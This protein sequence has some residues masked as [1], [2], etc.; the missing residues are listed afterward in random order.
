MN[1]LVPQW[2]P[3]NVIDEYLLA[4]GW[5]HNG[6]GW[7]APESLRDAI[8]VAYGHGIGSRSRSEAIRLQV[9]VDERIFALKVQP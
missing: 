1:D 7:V 8:G 5:E 2:H 6:R 4:R 3:L 9:L